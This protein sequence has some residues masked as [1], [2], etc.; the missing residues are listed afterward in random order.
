[1]T[2][3]ARFRKLKANSAQYFGRCR[4]K[5]VGPDMSIDASTRSASGFVRPQVLEIVM[6]AYLPEKAL[7]V[8]AIAAQLASIA[9]VRGSGWIRRAPSRLPN[10]VRSEWLAP[11]AHKLRFV[12]AH[13]YARP[14]RNR[15]PDAYSTDLIA[16]CSAGDAAPRPWQPNRPRQLQIPIAL[17]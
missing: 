4:L 8:S 3:N 12:R 2:E 6:P 14:D 15:E 9:G 10:R 13:R 1:M 5:P 11:W 17:R 7:S 16:R